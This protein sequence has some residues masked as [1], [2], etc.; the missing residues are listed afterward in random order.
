MTYHFDTLTSTNDEARKS[1]YVDMDV[2]WADMQ[3][4]GRGQ[5]G[6]T[7]L[8][9]KGEN[10]TFSV[11]LEPLFLE[12]SK[13]FLL[14]E[15]TALSIYEMLYEYGIKSKIKWT[16]DI[17]VDNRKITGILIEHQLSGNF[18]RR[19]ILGVGIDVNQ[20]CFPQTLPN[21]TSMK[22][23]SGHSFSLEQVLEKFMICLRRNYDSI[24]RGDFQ[25]IQSKYH[26]LL[27]RL[28]ERHRFMAEDGK[29][30]YG[31]IR[32]VRPYGALIVENDSGQQKEYQFKEIEFVLSD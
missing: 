28:D 18:L 19:T 20:V 31:I 23:Q 2:I 6:H 16:N 7:W 29:F 12:A 24:R 11:V 10:L 3:S 17:Y 32:G 9:N 8:S 25:T 27:Y 30:F 14:S 13:Q 4:A 21:P 22:L 26:N 1:T 5:R 15:I